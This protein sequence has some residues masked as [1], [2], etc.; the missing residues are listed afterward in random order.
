MVIILIASNVMVWLVVL[1][2]AFLLLGSLRAQGLLGWQLAQLA[3]T[4]PRRLG[5]D[6]LKPGKK[7]PDFAL[8]DVSSKE[9]SLHDFA[10]RKVLLV[11]TQSGCGPCQAVVPELNRLHDKGEVL[12]LAVNNGEPESTR[13][14]A[15]E[16]GA[17]FPVLA[18]EKFSVAKR[19]QVFA[20][21]FAFLL[22]EQGFI[23]SK[24]IAGT[25]EYLGYVLNGGNQG[26]PYHD[27][28]EFDEAD[29]AVTNGPV[30]TKEV[31]HV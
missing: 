22:N 12:I 25:K 7:A 19:Y 21:P 28:P 11:F 9:V 4:T 20:T 13:R 3:A 24:G 2:L 8:P 18:Q 10:G 26:E 15:T 5:R 17:R 31:A 16:T 14:W 29:N 30:S 27:E 23:R 1:F 6:G